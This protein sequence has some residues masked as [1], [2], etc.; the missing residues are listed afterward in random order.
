MQ[1]AILVFPKLTVLDAIG[2]SPSLRTTAAHREKAPAAIVE[3]AR[4][5]FAAAEK[6]S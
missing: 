5:A 4:N 6:G 1:I 2:P 3:A